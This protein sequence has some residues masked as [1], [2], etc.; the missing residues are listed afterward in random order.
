MKFNKKL[1]SIIKKY[2]KHIPP[3]YWFDY[4][5]LK[6]ILNDAYKLLQNIKISDNDDTCCICLEGNNLMKTSCCHNSIHHLCLVKVLCSFVASCPICRARIEKVI[7][8]NND[9]ERYDNKI[10]TLISIIQL[11]INKIEN[12]YRQKLIPKKYLRKYCYYN[13]TAV[14][15][16]TKKIDKYLRTDIKGHFIELMS[17]TSLYKELQDDEKRPR[18]FDCIFC[19]EKNKSIF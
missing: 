12:V 13:Y 19:C 9:V 7:V 17:K 11:N 1:T 18:C 10:L 6:K 3:H 15:K 8:Y 16:I 4:K 2:N 14:I 5:Y